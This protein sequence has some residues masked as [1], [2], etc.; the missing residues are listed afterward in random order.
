MLCLIGYNGV[1]GVFAEAMNDAC[2]NEKSNKL[3]L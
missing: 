3:Q 2:N 1:S